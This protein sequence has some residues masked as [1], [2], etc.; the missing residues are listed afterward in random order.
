VSV[1]INSN[2]SAT[3]ASNNL[4]TANG[5]LHRSLDRLSS[6]TKIVNPADD[7]GGLAVS[8]KLSAT[9]KRQGAVSSNISNASS[10][11]QT[12]DGALKIAAKILDRI[13]ELK[14]LYFDVTKNGSDKANYNSELNNLQAQLTALA[15]EKFNGV[16]LFGSNDMSIFVTEDGST[17]SA[18]TA[19]SVDLAGPILTPVFPPVSEDFSSL[20]NWTDTSF[21]TG[22]GGSSVSGNVLSL[23]VPG[24]GTARVTTQA[25]YSGAFTMSVEMR[26]SWPNITMG[27]STIANGLSN[28][29]DGSW[30]TIT[31]TGDGSG[32]TSAFL[33]GA[34]SAFEAHSGI[35]ASGAIALN[36]FGNG[37]SQAR[38]L[39]ISSTTTVQTALSAV[40][41]AANLGTLS[42]S[43]VT[44]AI[45][46]LA[47]HRAKN[48]ATQSR[49][50]FANELLTTNKANLEAA[51]SRIIDVDVADES[52]QLARFN[53]L[54]QASTSMLTQANQSAQIALKLLQ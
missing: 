8:M 30:H 14:T 21:L 53:T 16:S 43:S 4:A 10:F 9:A 38:N 37:S 2:Y 29:S 23:N 47:T 7:A 46:S 22:G 19:T 50:D 51:N 13:S 31:I 36:N 40:T 45:Q 28:F 17:S 3:V 32:N 39:S 15:S 18:V 54:V 26:G 20:S 6:G 42:L 11:L 5:F 49:L 12:Q 1:V 27:G 33:D 35:P 52:T 48:G 44:S 25:T 34:S 24:T 41:V